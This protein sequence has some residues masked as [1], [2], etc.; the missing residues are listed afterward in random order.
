VFIGRNAD[1]SVD[2][3]L[4]R[5]SEI[6]A[7]FVQVP[8]GRF[9]RQGDRE[10]PYSGPV[11]IGE[12]DDFLLARFPVT[13][14]EYLEFLNDLS[15]V[16]PERAALRVP[17]ESEKAGFYWPR[18]HDGKFVLPTATWLEGA[19]PERRKEARRL[20]QC[21]LDWQEDW[22][23]Y[24]VSWEDAAAFGAWF[25]RREGRLASLPR[26]GMWEKAARGA[27]G[28]IYPFGNEF[29]ET[30]ANSMR[31]NEGPARPSP[32]DGFPMDESPVGVRGLCGNA[33]SWC[34]DDADDEGRRISRGG[35]WCLSGVNLRSTSRRA[36]SPRHV[37]YHLGLRMVILPR[38]AGTSAS[39]RPGSTE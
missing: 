9:L 3:T 22:P 29:D 12:T 35:S 32:V 33:V 16:D 34:L 37:G 14:R 31:T 27:D 21:P 2:V 4:Y 10:N 26:D 36:S 11:E 17:R 6:P 18:G 39:R 30:Y 28:R 15:A 23:V 19:A 20:V 25:S 7:G 5:E 38:V 24:G 8:A 1:E 13:C